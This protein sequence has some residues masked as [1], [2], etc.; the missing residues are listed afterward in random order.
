VRGWDFRSRR[1]AFLMQNPKS[2]GIITAFTVDSN[3]NW[4]V[5]GTS[6]GFYTL[7]DLRFTTAVRTWRH[8]TREAIHTLAQCPE[9]VEDCPAGVFAGAGADGNQVWLWDLKSIACR[10]LFRSCSRT[11]PLPPLQPL[12]ESSSMVDSYRI[13]ESILPAMD[14][15]CQ[16]SS[17]SSSSPLSP[18]MTPSLSS[19]SSA[20]SSSSS[21]SSPS[22]SYV[23]TMF[24]TSNYILA[25]GIDAH[26]RYWDFNEGTLSRPYSIC[27]ETYRMRPSLAQS[28]SIN[29]Y[30][31]HGTRVVEEYPLLSKS[32][33]VH[34]AEIDHRLLSP[35]ATPHR[36]AILDLKIAQVPQNI[37]ITASRDSTIKC[38]K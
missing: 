11:D 15:S 6:R 7:W 29:R 12:Q 35:V 24:P 27:G 20:S 2:A 5:L 33:L 3:H 4:I 31:E 18:S 23:K 34:Q 1:E 26:V 13:E 32:G 14:F 10:R 9:G 28:S 21:S 19:Q 36:D 8:P 16:Q 37:L 25:A 22:Q 38:W 30:V 17:S